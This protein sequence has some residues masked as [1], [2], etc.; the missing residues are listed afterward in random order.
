VVSLQTAGPE[1]T[2]ALGELIGAHLSPGDV[3]VLDAELGLGKTCLAKG[4]AHGVGR[5]DPA[6]VTSPAFSLVNEYPAEGGAP[7]LYHMDFYRLE[8]LGPTDEQ[9]LGE[10]VRD[11]QAVSVIEWG[12]RFVDRLVPEHLQ[13]H[14]DFEGSPPSDGRRITV[15]PHGDTDRFA[16]L[17][18]AL[19]S[20]ADARP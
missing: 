13:I 14:L 1:E 10:Y 15:E 11:E 20:R 3:V 2:L 6:T 18:A 8:E 9:L 4:I 17:I 16:A 12:S 19:E 5:H 7:A